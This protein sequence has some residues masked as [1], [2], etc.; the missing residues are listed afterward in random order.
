MTA[1]LI[2]AWNEGAEAGAKLQ[3]EIE[4]AKLT[5]EPP[6]GPIFNPYMPTK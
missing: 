5:G 2:E 3:H 4:R 6:P 1:E